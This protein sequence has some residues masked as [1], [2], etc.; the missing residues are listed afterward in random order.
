MLA[1]L[2]PNIKAGPTPCGSPSW[3]GGMER[4][5]VCKAIEQGQQ[6]P[7][8]PLGAGRLIADARSLPRTVTRA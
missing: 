6:G 5:Q 1:G 4:G 8:Q 7:A 2:Y 3:G